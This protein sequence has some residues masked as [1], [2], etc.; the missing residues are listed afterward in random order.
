SYAPHS[1]PRLM[2]P[3]TVVFGAAA[4]LLLLAYGTICWIEPKQANVSSST[5][6]PPRPAAKSR[7]ESSTLK[8]AR[9]PEYA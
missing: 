9:T 2:R 5:A 8:S 7:S 6:H 4:G 3:L 1:M